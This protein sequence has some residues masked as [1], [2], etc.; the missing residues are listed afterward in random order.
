[1][2][3]AEAMEELKL[4]NQRFL[5]N[6]ELLKKYSSK[7]KKNDDFIQNQ[8]EYM[9]SLIQS[10]KDLVERYMK[11]KLEIQ[12]SNLN[13]VIDFKGR[14]YSIAEGLLLKQGLFDWHER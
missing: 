6:I 13:S 3:V 11:I 5:K 2:T 7:A 10:S 8:Q 4:I 1:M 14:K 9:K 12:K